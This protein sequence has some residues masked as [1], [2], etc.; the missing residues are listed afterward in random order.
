MIES[1]FDSVKGTV[2]G[3]LADHI[4]ARR[5]SQLS[6]ARPP[7]AGFELLGE[8]LKASYRLMMTRYNRAAE[9]QL[10]EVLSRFDFQLAPASA[11][12]QA[13]FDERYRGQS[14]VQIRRMQQDE[15]ERIR[16]PQIVLVTDLGSGQR[17][18]VSW[19]LF[20]A[21]GFEGGIYSEANEVVW[22]IALVNSKEPV[23]LETLDHINSRIEG[24]ALRSETCG[25]GHRL[26]AKAGEA[27][28]AG[29]TGPA[30]VRW[31]VSKEGFSAAASAQVSRL[32]AHWSTYAQLDLL[33]DYLV[34]S[35]GD[36]TGVH[37]A[38]EFELV[39]P[40]EADSE[41]I[42]A[43]TVEQ[44]AR[45]AD[46]DQE[47]INQIKTALIE[48]CINAAEHGESPDHRIHQRFGV[49]EDRLTITVTNKGNRFAAAANGASAALG[50]SP[51]RGRGLQIIQALMDEVKFDRTD[52]GTSLVMVKFLRRPQPEHQSD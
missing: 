36:E 22:V 11:F 39:I 10:V 14:R 1:G 46:F 29:P 42:A 31:H 17:H 47:S 12:N 8:K 40:V 38:S 13:A 37:P 5:R 3:V 52:D 2:D 48:A 15:A 21:S 27:D 32:M 28:S 23:D 9:S 30:V 25:T 41:L 50:G 7:L 18:G 49:S 44:I 6:G 45:A 19:R 43:R 26:S 4:R 51:K 20:A 35:A 34:K 33:H 24:A 16:L